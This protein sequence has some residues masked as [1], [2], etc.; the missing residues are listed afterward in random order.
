[1]RQKHITVK[2]LSTRLNTLA[3]FAYSVTNNDKSKIEI[4]INRLRLKIAK[5][6]LTANNLRKPYIKALGRA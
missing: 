1:M 3:W 5:D 6:E 2:E 4:F